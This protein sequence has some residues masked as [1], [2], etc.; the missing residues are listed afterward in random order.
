[1]G[2]LDEGCHCYRAAEVRIVVAG[3][4]RAQ[5]TQ[6]SVGEGLSRHTQSEEAN[7][8]CDLRRAADVV[9]SRP[10]PLGVADSR[11]KLGMATHKSPKGKA[12]VSHRRVA[13]VAPL[14]PVPRDLRLAA[15]VVQ[16]HQIKA[17]QE[18]HRPVQRTRARRQW[19]RR[20]KPAGKYTHCPSSGSL[21]TCHLAFGYSHCTGSR[22]KLVS[23]TFAGITCNDND[24]CADHCHL[25]CVSCSNDKQSTSSVEEAPA[26]GVERRRHVRSQAD[27]HCKEDQRH[28][29]T[30]QS[31][32][33]PPEVAQIPR[34]GNTREAQRRNAAGL[35]GRE[36]DYT[37]R[38]TEQ[39][40][41][42]DH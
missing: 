34:V 4:R 8:V 18:E 35:L 25:P 7:A 32:T 26:V 10:R 13:V 39:D 22:I 38:Q 20:M 19:W 11:T 36:A 30:G 14:Q 6:E 16:R 24:R 21:C 29:G 5:K 37:Y 41:H 1:M 15:T 40:N 27:S 3:W 17:S 33:S 23:N 28:L 12:S 31:C 42:C 2:C 9:G